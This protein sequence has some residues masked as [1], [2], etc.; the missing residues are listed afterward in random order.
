MV[1]GELAQ[2]KDIVII[3]GG[4]GGYNAAI[5][6]AQSGHQ[7]TLIENHELGGICLNK[8]CIPSK[9]FTHAA[10]RFNDVKKAGQFGIETQEISFSLS[11]LHEHKSKVI[12]GLR[13]GVESLLRKNKIEIIQG[14]AAFISE[15]KVGV[16]SGHQY[17]VF[18]FQHAIVAT[19]SS[20]EAPA[21][22]DIDHKRVL[23]C[24]S[25]YEIEAVPQ[26][27]LVYGSDYM[28]L[29]VAMSFHM[30]G[31]KVSLILPDEEDDFSFDD[32]IN[33]EL[34]RIFK[35]ARIQILRKKKVSSVSVDS[36]GITVAMK[37]SDSDEEES[38]H[39]S[40]LFVSYKQIPNTGEIGLERAKVDL[41]SK[42]HILVQDNMKTSNP[43]IFAAG[44]V[45]PGPKTAVKAIKQGKIAAE[46]VSGMN[47]EL[48]SFFI[49]EVIHTIPPI[50]S[51]GLTEKE[52]EEQGYHVKTGEFTLAGNGYAAIMG[53]KNGL[54]KIIMDRETDVLL[55]VH[56]IGAR[57]AELIQ[58]GTVALEMGA[59]DE[60]LSF[61]FYP[62]PGLAESLMEAA[63]DLKEKGIH[64]SPKKS[65]SKREKVSQ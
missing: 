58:S 23:D 7:V 14:K 5:R 61:P 65:V 20:P 64:I 44:D 55:G 35:K 60:D 6:A 40:H 22:I 24:R 11:A 9:V 32:S 51:V 3:G 27:L 2:E 16:E 15:Q 52:A 12:K 13:K 17:E 34:R 41:D 33:R 29:E 62:H 18:T 59:R 31:A 25:V 19:G 43:R 57:A 30:F 21:H 50:A 28:S 54:V 39:G 10:S 47:S 46:A 42:G 1:V 36:E 49:P 4:P 37:G 45:T 53:E 48:D 26:H 38:I 8:G 63:E 56:M